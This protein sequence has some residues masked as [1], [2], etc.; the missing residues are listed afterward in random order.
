MNPSSNDIGGI[1]PPMTPDE[2]RRIGQIVFGE[3]WQTPLSKSVGVEAR[4]VRYWVAGDREIPPHRAQLIRALIPA[5]E[6]VA[7]EGVSAEGEPDRFYLFHLWYPRFQCRVYDDDDGP[8][9]LA[10][11]CYDGDYAFLSNFIW[12]DPAPESVE[13]LQSL[14]ARADAAMAEF[15]QKPVE[16]DL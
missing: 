16:N 14:F 1:E 2:L 9:A 10:P 6:W 11:L 4:L 8:H 15:D 5:D 13:D 7:G 3:N 12:Y